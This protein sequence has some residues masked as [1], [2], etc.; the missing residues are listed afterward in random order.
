MDTEFH[1][2]GEEVHRESIFKFFVT[3]K[4]RIFP[5]FSVEVLWRLEYLPQRAQSESRTFGFKRGIF[6]DT[7]YHSKGALIVLLV[8]YFR[9]CNSLIF[10]GILCTEDVISLYLF[11]LI[12]DKCFNLLSVKLSFFSVQHTLL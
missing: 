12:R 6:L 5:M 1:R 4:T 9:S 7:R 10:I 11:V 3:N 2:E 8:L